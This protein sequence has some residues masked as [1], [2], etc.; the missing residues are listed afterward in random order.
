MLHSLTVASFKRLQKKATKV[1]RGY[2][3]KIAARNQVTKMYKV[4]NLSNQ[5]TILS[6]QKRIREGFSYPSTIAN[7]L[8]IYNTSEK[9]STKQREIIDLQK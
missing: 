2:Q 1:S 4:S 9:R 5:Y 6:L 7:S 3:K 8:K